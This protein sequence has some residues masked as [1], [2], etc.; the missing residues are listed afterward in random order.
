MTKPAALPLWWG[1]ISQKLGA[2]KAAEPVEQLI[3]YQMRNLDPRY[4]TAC[5]GR[6]A[7]PPA[8]TFR[9]NMKMLSN[10]NASLSDLC[11]PHCVLYNERS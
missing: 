1:W 6:C 9:R 5:A 10:R 7:L 11:R 2:E 4:V 8:G 3:P